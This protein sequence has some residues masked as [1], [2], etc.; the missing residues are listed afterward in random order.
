MFRHCSAISPETC[1]L[2][3][4]PSLYSCLLTPI[5]KLLFVLSCGLISFYWDFST[6]LAEY[7]GAVLGV[8]SALFYGR[9]VNI[10]KKVSFLLLEITACFCLYFQ[11]C[12]FVIIFKHQ[13]MRIILLNLKIDQVSGGKELSTLFF[14]YELSFNLSM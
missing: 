1:L 14:I 7:A 12:C 11:G 6:L 13:F 4:F 5:E 2:K 8:L 10:W 3:N 9:R